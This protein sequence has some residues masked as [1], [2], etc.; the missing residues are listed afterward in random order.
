M[1]KRRRK[2]IDSYIENKNKLNKDNNNLNTDN[3]KQN[4]D[5]NKSK[6]NLRSK[7][8]NESNNESSNE[9]NNLYTINN[10]YKIFLP[11]FI[12]NLE[13]YRKKI[14][15]ITKKLII[16][17]NSEDIN[18]IFNSEFKYHTKSRDSNESEK[19]NYFET[20][21]MI[22][23]FKLITDR[24]LQ[25]IYEKTFEDLDIVFKVDNEIKEKEYFDLDNSDN[26]D[27]ENM[28]DNLENMN[29]HSNNKIILQKIK[30]LLRKGFGNFIYKLIIDSQEVTD[31]FKPIIKN[32]HSYCQEQLDKINSIPFIEQKTEAW[33]KMRENMI[34]A[35]V[36]GYIDSERCGC[37]RSKETEQILEKTY[38]KEKKSLVGILDP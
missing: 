36:C 33:F 29:N 1:L 25:L 8:N 18:N 15:K 10:F 22:Q 26:S 38:L 19:L 27:D 21:N 14:R 34:S 28:D 9:L 31:Y 6:Y 24:T 3:N 32:I 12:E 23:D 2:D 20:S 5:N 16:E 4:M 30:K 35:S 37:G 7:S 13:L 17:S 11:K